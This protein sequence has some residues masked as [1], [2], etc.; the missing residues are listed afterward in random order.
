MD[1]PETLNAN[2]IDAQYQLWKT[3]PDSVSRD[4][5][6]FFEGFELAG[7]AKPDDA[8]STCTEDQA[9]RQSRVEALK[10]RYRDVGHLLACL[11]PLAACPISHPLLDISAFR[12]TPDD[13]N[14]E[15]YTRRF[16]QTRRA[17]LRD[18]IQ[19]LRETYCRSVGAEYMHLQ[20][21]EERGWLQD[22]M[23]PVRNHPSLEPEAKIRILNKLYQAA[24][25]EQF[26][27]KKYMGQT[28]FSLEGGE[29]LIP[30]LDA[31]LLHVSGENC[32]EI[33]LGMAHRGRLN[34]QTNILYKSYEEIFREFIN[35]YDPDTLVGAGD[36]KYHNGYLADIK[37]ANNQM[38]R[39]FLVNN[40]SHLESVDPV[41]EGIARA[42]QDLPDRERRNQVLPIL[43]HGD[44]AFAG[45]GVVAETL[46][47]SQLDGYSTEG[48]IHIVINNQIGYTTLP[49]NARSTRYSTDIAKM[50]MVPIFH[51]HGENP[52][53]VVHVIRLA[54]DYRMTFGKDVVIDMICYRRYGHNEG[55]EPY[56]TQPQMYDRIRERSPVHHIYAQKMLKEG[57]ATKAET[58]HIE[59]EMNLCLAEA[60]QAA[61]DNPRVLPRTQFYENWEE[62]HGNYSHEPLKTGVAEEKLIAFARRL[63]TVPREFSVHPKLQRLL[64]KRLEAVEN[65]KGIDW[66]N[67]EAL[68]FASILAEGDPVRLSGQ[69]SGRGTF[70]QRH[71]VLTDTKTETHFVPLNAVAENQGVFSV[72]NS[73][74]SE[75]AVLG[76]EYGYSVTQ[77][78][79]LVIWEAQFGDFANNA[80]GVIDLYIV[81]GESKWQRL[82]GLVMLLPHGLDGLGPE[83]SSARPERFFQLC[84]DNNIQ[85]CNPTTP[86]QYFH[87]LRAQAKRSFRKPLVLLSPK[88]LLRHPLA[89]SELSDMSSGHFQEVLDHEDNPDAPRR[90]IFCSGKIYYDLLQRRESLKADT[91]AVVRLEQVYPFPRTQLEKAVEKYRQTKQWVWVQE[92]P[93]NMGAWNFVAPRLETLTET[94][95]AYIGRKTCSSPATGFSNIYKEEQASIIEQ[96]VGASSDKS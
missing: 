6:F 68:T 36:V 51:V 11:D 94:P 48:T 69:D 38:L 81:S 89:V 76:F 91:I 93:A 86:G 73:M 58:E 88:S 74:L 92:E 85:I 23:E 71:C 16:S 19:M 72:Y 34:V 20:D 9:L 44:A 64:D 2:Y 33:I 25:F 95:I 82:S 17:P 10:Y 84:A 46:N 39:V 29:S 53:A 96:A 57:V 27:N 77:P 15:F 66:A 49:E 83:H 50:L 14:E 79:G 7:A 42:R 18:I 80:Q 54:A 75:A 26:L 87:L 47:L 13:L 55:D 59:N 30:M 90:V 5:R 65:G 52:E 67:A 40:P 12:L 35:S 70:S 56:F 3:D 37:L 31:L 62:F 24:L 60:F 8:A 32:K 4:W 45:Q 61:Q 43:I 41:V 78:R 22:R 1:I 63:N 28:R 21:P